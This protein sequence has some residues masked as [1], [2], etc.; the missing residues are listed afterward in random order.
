M[1]V[2]ITRLPFWGNF[3]LFTSSGFLVLLVFVVVLAGGLFGLFGQC[4]DDFRFFPFSV[5]RNILRYKYQIQ[6]MGRL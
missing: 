5:Y 4:S 3:L 6:T 2:N 1:L